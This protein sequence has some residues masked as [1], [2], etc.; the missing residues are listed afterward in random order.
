MVIADLKRRASQEMPVLQNVV[1]VLENLVP[2]FLVSNPSVAVVKFQRGQN[3]MMLHSR[4]DAVVLMD[5]DSLTEVSRWAADPADSLTEVSRW[6]M[7]GAPL[8]CYSPDGACLLLVGDWFDEETG[9]RGST[10][11]YRWGF[12]TDHCQ[13]LL[14]RHCSCVCAGI[15]TLQRAL[16]CWRVRRS[17]GYGGHSHHGSCFA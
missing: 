16:G 7:D 12:R 15:C 1:P 11:S 2:A 5:A 17:G 9:D 6:S 3:N 8:M 10:V 13:A 14:L 4:M